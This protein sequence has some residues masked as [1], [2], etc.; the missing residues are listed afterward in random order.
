MTS[1]TRTTPICCS[2][3]GDYQKA[4]DAGAEAAQRNPRDARNFFLTGKALLRLE[5]PDVALKWLEQAIAL[6]PS[7]PDPH[8]LLSQA[9][10]RLGRMEDAT[11]ALEA[12]RAA[13]ARA[14]K[15]R[16]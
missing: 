1:S 10:R 11:R 15:N 3:K 2:R 5:R 16:R 14:P 6:D 8:Y 13:S 12:F 4:F 7:Y 9:Y